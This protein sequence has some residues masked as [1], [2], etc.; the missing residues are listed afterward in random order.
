MTG[1]AVKTDA[2]NSATWRRGAVYQL[3]PK[4]KDGAEAL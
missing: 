4:R 3:I 1:K 2:G